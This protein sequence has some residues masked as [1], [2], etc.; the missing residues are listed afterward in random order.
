MERDRK[1]E[2]ERSGRLSPM[3][4]QLFACNPVHVCIKVNVMLIVVANK[5]Y[6][7]AV[8]GIAQQQIPTVALGNAAE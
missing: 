2:R 4:V 7:G 5:V 1:N 6:R 3:C 8:I